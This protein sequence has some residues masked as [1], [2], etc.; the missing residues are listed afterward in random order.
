MLAF[1]NYLACIQTLVLY[2]LYDQG[3]VSSLDEPLV[4][5]C[6]QFSIKDTFQDHYDITLRQLAAQ[7]KD[8][9]VE[10]FHTGGGGGG[11]PPPS[12]SFPPLPNSNLIQV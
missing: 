11:N 6:P 4:T 9:S 10:G 3:K 2:Q 5:Y 8:R 12:K 1:P 7:V